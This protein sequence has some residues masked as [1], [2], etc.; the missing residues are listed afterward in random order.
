ML[1][2]LPLDGS[3]EVVI[4]KY[5]KKR[6]DE[7]NNLYWKRLTEISQQAWIQG[8]QYSPEILAEYMKAMYLPE[9][10][11]EG[12]TLEGYEKYAILPD[13]S[14]SVIGSTTK[15]T[16]KGFAN[17]LTQVEVFG[18]ELGVHFSVREA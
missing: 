16:T 13:G 1:N 17:Y 6:R 5:V 9:E 7:A 18:V 10:Y 12:I 8:K 11:E 14:R 15:L 3:Q 2:N 4:R